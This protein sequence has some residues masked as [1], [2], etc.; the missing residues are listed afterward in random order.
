MQLTSG[1][2]TTTPQRQR[3]RP[4]QGRPVATDI[5]AASDALPCDGASRARLRELFFDVY[6]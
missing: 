1:T 5:E 6:F 3:P 4:S 2:G